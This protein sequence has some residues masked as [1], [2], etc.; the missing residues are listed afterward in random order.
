MSRA[1]T[2]TLPPFL[3]SNIRTLTTEHHQSH[4]TWSRAFSFWDLSHALVR[5]IFRE[6]FPPFRIDC[7]KFYV[8][9]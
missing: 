6:H 9:L 5:V 8:F 1:N 4:A 2:A 3:P 7:F